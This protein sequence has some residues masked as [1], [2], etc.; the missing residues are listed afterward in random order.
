[1]TRTDPV[2]SIQIT[3]FVRHYLLKA[4]EENGGAEKFREDWIQNI[5]VDILNAFLKLGL[6]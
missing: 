5:D 1:L 4:Q 3:E 6:F 2:H